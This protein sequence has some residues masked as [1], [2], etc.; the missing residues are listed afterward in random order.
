MKT[1]QTPSLFL[2]KAVDSET[3]EKLRA[4]EATAEGL[5]WAVLAHW[6]VGEKEA[7]ETDSGG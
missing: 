7:W 2:F 4:E 6:K 1:D 5:G 3:K